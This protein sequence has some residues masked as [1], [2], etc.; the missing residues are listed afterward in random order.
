MK[1]GVSK[2]SAPAQSSSSSEFEPPR[3]RRAQHSPAVN[4][5]NDVSA[6][7]PPSAQDAHA[8]TAQQAPSTISLSGASL[9]AAAMATKDASG[10]T[11]QF[12]S[13]KSSSAPPPDNCA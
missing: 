11:P 10:A 2:A 1:T 7:A 5:G 6:S 8:S 4:D 3:P 12:Q 9:D 13:Q